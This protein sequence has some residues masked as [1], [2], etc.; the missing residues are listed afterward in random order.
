MVLLHTCQGEFDCCMDD[1][2]IN[3]DSMFTCQLRFGEKRL[4]KPQVPL[5]QGYELRLRHFESPFAEVRSKHVYGRMA[6]NIHEVLEISLKRSRETYRLKV[7]ED[8]FEIHHA[9]P[10][11]NELGHPG[12]CWRRGVSA[13]RRV[14]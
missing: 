4:V 13:G 5:Q 10:G 6:R 11:R 12:P 2:T 8:I 1:H 9:F 14:R 3:S 7:R